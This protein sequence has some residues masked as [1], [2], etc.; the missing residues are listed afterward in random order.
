META[1]ALRKDRCNLCG[2]LPAC[3]PACPQQI[4]SVSGQSVSLLHDDR[5]PDGCNDCITSCDSAVFSLA[6][7]VHQ[8][9]GIVPV[10]RVKG[11][12]IAHQVAY[13]RDPHESDG[14]LQDRFR[15][16]CER[17]QIPEQNR[18]F[19][20]TRGHGWGPHGNGGDS[21]LQ[22]TWEL[23]T[24][25]YFFR[26]ILTGGA[27]VTRFDERLEEV[28]QVLHDCGTPPIVTCLD[29]LL[30]DTL[31]PPEGLEG[32][33]TTRNR[34]GA[35]I[36]DG[37]LNIYTNYEPINGRERYVVSGLPAALEA[38]GA[39]TLAN[40][41]ALENYYHLL[42]IPRIEQRESVMEVHDME[43][44][45]TERMAVVTEQIDRAGPE[46]L[47]EWLHDLT[48]DL[49]RLVRYNGRFNHVLS[50]SYP[51]NDRVR[52]AFAKWNEMPL[53]GCDSPSRIILERT[54]R[55]AEEYR[56]FLA[57]LDRMQGEI[58]DLV[59]ILR[60]RVEMSMEAQNTRLLQNLDERSAIQLRLQ[61]LA[62]G[63]SVIVI[64][65][66]MTGLAS[67]LFK[68]LEKA[69]VIGSATLYTAV[70]IPIG[71][72]TAWYVAHK[73]IQKIKKKAG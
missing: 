37:A 50:A 44:A 42:M 52:E 20:E 4:L 36:L 70:F 38:H 45:L 17:L 35:Q 8:G 27:P 34:Y 41:G 39:F 47:E 33:I 56:T 32:L 19:G 53:P 9:L 3:V 63:L 22:L 7:E 46:Q 29:I 10:E 67:Y 72:A 43:Q 57:R 71:A 18:S 21:Q 59:A 13:L 28:V 23:H 2:G 16:V 24:E 26:A 54:D 1:I 65:Y 51:Y 14:Q 40:I 62:E 25:Y 31:I 30:L 58:S 73:G 48:G 15:Q 69:H 60:T 5:C 66:Y 11:A 12:S 6:E 64:T 68:A 61:E 55:V 49:T